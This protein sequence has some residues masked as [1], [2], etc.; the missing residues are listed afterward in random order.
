MTGFLRTKSA[1][2]APLLAMPLA[3]SS[4][5]HAQAD[6]TRSPD[7]KAQSAT[8]GA[9][10]SAADRKR[11]RRL[12]EEAA[13]LESKREWSAATAKLEEALGIVE[14]PGLR[15]HLAYCQE[16]QGLMVEALANYER[17]QQMIAGGTKAPDVAELLAPKR[18][19]LWAR[20]PK[21]RIVARAPAVID[22][23]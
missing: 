18:D 3:A 19:A 12:F 21:L 13:E 9:E 7:A 15:Y 11:A 23:V 6:Q 4:Q 16:E 14:T 5:A 8:A 10:A 20:I 17:A 22:R 1:L 2:I